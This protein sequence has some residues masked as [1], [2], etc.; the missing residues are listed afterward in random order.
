M[1]RVIQGE[2]Y[3]KPENGSII[4]GLMREFSSATRS[5]YQAIHKH[6]LKNNDITLYVKKNYMKSLNQRYVKDAVAIAS[7]LIFE[8]SIFGGKKS[9]EDFVSGNITKEEWICRR[10]NQLYSRGDKTKNGN[11]NIRCDDGVI[12]VNDPAGRGKWVEGKLFIPDKWENFCRDCYD[13]RII[14]DGDRFK[15]KISYEET[16]PVKITSKVN[17][18]VGID[19]NPDGVALVETNY[20][21]N[22]LKHFYIREQRIQFASKNKREYDIRILAKEVIDYALSV[23]KS[24]VLEEL[25]FKNKKSKCRKFN[26]M[27]HNFI[28]RKILESIKSKAYKLGVEVLEVNPA[29]TSILGKLKYQRMYSLNRHTSAS[30]IIARRGVGLK[31]KRDFKVSVVTSS[32]KK[33]KLNL[34]GRGFSVVITQKAFNYLTTLTASCL[35]PVFIGIGHSAGGIPASESCS[36]TGRAGSV[37]EPEKEIKSITFREKKGSLL[38]L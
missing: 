16:C 8:N 27:R 38:R 26:R 37:I 21:G 1:R 3:F 2:V 24:I 17:G 9:W 13:V 7:G 14:K 30:L 31:E 18:V 6:N 23:N 12:K 19:V 33:E 25:S 11:P 34:E 4:T 35:V 29:F 22:L 28:Y 32:E 10:N 36:I 20:E 5:A 15:V